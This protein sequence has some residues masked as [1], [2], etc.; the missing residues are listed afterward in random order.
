MLIETKARTTLT[1]V[2]APPCEIAVLHVG[3]Y[4]ALRDGHDFPVLDNGHEKRALAHVMVPNASE[5]VVLFWHALNAPPAAS[6][7]VPRQAYKRAGLLT[8]EIA[9][10]IKAYVRDDHAGACS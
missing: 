5:W 9:P 4:N 3:F 6:V 7:T 1:V 2:C 8:P 10:H